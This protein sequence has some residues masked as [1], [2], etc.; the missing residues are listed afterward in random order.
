MKRDELID[1]LKSSLHGMVHE[2]G[3]IRLEVA[4]P[5]VMVWDARRGRLVAYCEMGADYE[6]AIEEFVGDYL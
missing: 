2:S 4:R 5:R 6:L 3:H 1:A